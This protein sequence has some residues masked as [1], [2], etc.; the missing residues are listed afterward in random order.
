M[1]PES[2]FLT[3]A[4]NSIH[5]SSFDGLSVKLGHFCGGI[6]NGE[7]GAESR[8]RFA[9]GGDKESMLNG[10]GLIKGLLNFSFLMSNIGML[11]EQCL[12]VAFGSADGE[13]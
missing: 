8:W 7:S 1:T 5:C 6:G 4:D 13:L 12:P 10:I 11:D 9:E 3:E 2:E